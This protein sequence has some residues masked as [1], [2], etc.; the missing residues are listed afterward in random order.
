[1]RV[2]A[3]AAGQSRALRR[4][5]VAVTSLLLLVTAP[6][7]GAVAEDLSTPDS[8]VLSSL[9]LLSSAP[10]TAT[11]PDVLVQERVTFQFTPMSPGVYARYSVARKTIEIAHRWLETDAATLAAVIAHE[12]VHV[13]DAESGFLA[14]GG[15]S[16]CIDSEIRAFRTSGLFWTE[17]FG[18]GGKTAPTSEL[19]RQLNL[20]AQRLQDDPA[21]LDHL[22]RE[23]YTDQCA[24]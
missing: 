8:R 7:A 15:A 2:R 20:V 10:S 3:I 19:E 18:P 5:L 22:V 17:T 13:Q 11:L 6:P 24:S 14:S 21:E 12:A 4:L 16:A 1:M 23:A 9:A